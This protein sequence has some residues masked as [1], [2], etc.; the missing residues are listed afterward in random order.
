MKCVSFSQASPV[1]QM[2]KNPSVI[3]ETWVRFLGQQD[4]LEKGMATHITILAWR[5]LWTEEPV[6]HTS[7]PLSSKAYIQSESLRKTSRR[8][9]YTWLCV[10]AFKICAH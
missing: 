2:V 8:M 9:L 10:N 6:G 1:A 7:F 4:L 3:Q 5:T